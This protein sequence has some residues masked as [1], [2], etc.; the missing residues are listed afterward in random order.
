MNTQEQQKLYAEVV[1]K[2]WENAEFKKELIANPVK[3]IEELTGIKMNIPQG[4]TLVVADQTDESTVYLNI[5][6]KI[7]VSEL[8]LT[9]EQLEM[10]AGGTDVL[11]WGGVTI[12]A[13]FA[14]AVIAGMQK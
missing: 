5:P 9:D 7:D 3:A 8:E 11:F 2:A 1:Q 10:V 14:G 13:A 4:Q 12:G 6:R